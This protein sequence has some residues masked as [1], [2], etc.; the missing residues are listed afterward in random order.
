MPDP[1]VSVALCIVGS[2]QIMDEQITEKHSF[3]NFFS[4]Q[5]ERTFHVF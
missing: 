2:Q 5:A 4:D 3:L 1:Y